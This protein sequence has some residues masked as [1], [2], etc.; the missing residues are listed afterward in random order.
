M[1]LFCR[2]YLTSG[3]LCARNYRSSFHG[4]YTSLYHL[5]LYFQSQTEK[6]FSQQLSRYIFRGGRRRGRKERGTVAA[7]VGRLRCPG[8]LGH[9]FCGL[10]VLCKRHVLAED[11][12]S[13]HAI[14]GSMS[15]RRTHCVVCVCPVALHV[16]SV[17]EACFLHGT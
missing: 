10:S 17:Q 9:W 15:L 8:Y 13:T 2:L 11:T 3:L 12:S 1:F 16:P 6:L 14:D 7:G 4:F 5:L